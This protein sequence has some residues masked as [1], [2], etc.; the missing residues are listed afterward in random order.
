MAMLFLASRSP[1]RRRILEELEISFETLDVETE[2]VVLAT[3]D[4]TVLENARRKA[5]AACERVQ[6]GDVVI[7]SDTVVENDG[8]VLGK[9]HTAALAREYLTRLSGRAVTAWSGVACLCKGTGDGVVVAAERATATMR[10]FSPQEIEWYVGTGEP[11]TRAGAF[12]IS[13]FGEIFV[14]RL[15]GSYS[16]FAGL[17]KR[18]LFFVLSKVAAAA[19]FLPVALPPDPA[20]PQG[21]RRQVG[22]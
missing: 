7:A 11:L 8:D 3:P 18:A 15:D 16:C 9:P 10:T 2:E 13:R 22:V 20:P 21:G 19:P 1:Q 14:E 4:A 6:D 5:C 12:G 17:P